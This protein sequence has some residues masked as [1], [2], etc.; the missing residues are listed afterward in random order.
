MP[1]KVKPVD[2]SLKGEVARHLNNQNWESASYSAYLYAESLRKNE[3]Y[4][5]ALKYYVL[6]AYIDLSGLNSA[7]ARQTQ[8]TPLKKLFVGPKVLGQ[9][10]KTALKTDTLDR[11]IDE[12]YQVRL[13]FRYFEKDVFKSIISGSIW[14]D[15][16]SYKK[17]ANK[18]PKNLEETSSIYD[19]ED[20][21]LYDL[22][23]DEW[24]AKYVQ[25]EIDKVHAK[26][27]ALDV[28]VDELEDMK[29][30]E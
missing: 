12:A 24:Y 18:P 13:P 20:E 5:E 4:D 2:H 8:I 25:P 10:Q 17:V 14:E 26:R 11:C 23:D 28:E 16:S 21:S 1:R 19:D 6:E 15:F 22:P 29:A 27:D 3:L 30:L 7:I 9:L